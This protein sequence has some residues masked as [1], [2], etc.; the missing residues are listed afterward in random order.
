MSAAKGSRGN[1]RSTRDDAP[2]F[3]RH[4]AQRRTIHDLQCRSKKSRGGRRCARDDVGK[5]GRPDCSDYSPADPDLTAGHRLT[6][7]KIVT[8]ASLSSSWPG[9]TRSYSQSRSGGVRLQ[10]ARSTGADGRVTSGHDEKRRGQAGDLDQI[11]P[12]SAMTYPSGGA[13]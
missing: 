7:A 10:C 2:D 11:D 4:G 8:G 12:L 1:N 5:V 3:P 13:R 6:G 9:V